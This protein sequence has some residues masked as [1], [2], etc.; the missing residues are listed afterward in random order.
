[1]ASLLRADGPTKGELREALTILEDVEPRCR[2]LYGA[3]HPEAQDAQRELDCARHMLAIF[4]EVIAAAR[5][6]AAAQVTAAFGDDAQDPRFD[7]DAAVALERESNNVA[8]P[9]H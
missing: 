1:M 7:A 5:A 3:A 8:A 9:K 6:R 2:R 4:D